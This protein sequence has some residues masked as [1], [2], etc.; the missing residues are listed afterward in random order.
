MQHFPHDVKAQAGNR[1]RILSG[2]M[3]GHA[4]TVVSSLARLR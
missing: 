2:G 1:R 3:F 4:M